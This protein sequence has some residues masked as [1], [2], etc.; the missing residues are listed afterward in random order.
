MS[1]HFENR[2]IVGIVE[3][4]QP[5]TFK[6]GFAAANCNLQAYV[7][8]IEFAAESETYERNVA[9]P[10]YS[11]DVDIIARESGT[12]R[13]RAEVRG[14]GT[15]K[16]TVPS[17][18]P[19]VEACGTQQ[20]TLQMFPLDEAGSVD[21]TRWRPG[22]LLT[23]ASTNATAY[24][25][26][27]DTEADEVLIHTVT[28]T[29]T[30][31]QNWTGTSA[32]GAFTVA[33]DTTAPVVYG[34]VW[35]PRSDIEV[36]SQGTLTLDV[37]PVDL[38]GDTM[39]IGSVTYTFKDTVASA[40]DIKI[41]ATVAATQANAVA[42][43]NGTGTPGT[44]YGTGT[45]YNPDAKMDPF[46]TDVA[47]L[48]ARVAGSVGNAIATTETFTAA[49]N[50]FDAATLGTYTAGRAYHYSL[51]EYKRFGT[52]GR[53]T[54]HSIKNAVGD[55]EISGDNIGAPAIFDFNMK[56]CEQG[57]D[58]VATPTAIPYENNAT[59]LFRGVHYK[60][61]GDAAAPQAQCKLN[62]F[63][64]R[65]GNDIE[66]DEH[67]TAAEPGIVKYDIV[68]R[69][70]S[71]EH[72]LRLLEPSVKSFFAD[73]KNHRTGRLLMDNG[74][75]AEGNIVQMIFHKIQYQNYGHENVR[76]KIHG[77]LSFGIKSPDISIGDNEWFLIKR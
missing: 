32:A 64:F 47:I 8:S 20:A 11:Q 33:Q 43:I 2:K 38:D 44:E 26:D 56:G 29:P 21:L 23:Q 60:I 62:S 57:E 49:T 36:F 27:V 54:R 4:D 59:P 24:L 35:F 69:K 65:F 18:A 41:G 72:S 31:S 66:A 34:L 58:E 14:S 46:A 50:V 61:T 76:R 13:A 6:D 40:N 12:I 10:T 67:A 75:T 1:D 9:S 22:V 5:D 15:S 3:Q 42:A 30:D 68:G 28:G 45:V 73:Y 39:T 7:D 53:S 19:W 71:G 70:P 77:R 63:R 74:K 37:N 48:T 55:C 52:T 17:W 25:V 16:T 51:A